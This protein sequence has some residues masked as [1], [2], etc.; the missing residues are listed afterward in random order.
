M[1]ARLRLL[2]HGATAATRSGS[3]ASDEPIE[4]R[5]RVRIS[6]LASQMPRFDLILTSPARRAL[7][8]AAALGLTA[9]VEPALRDA[10]FGRWRGRSLAQVFEEE[11]EAASLWSSEPQ[12][13][14][15]EGESISAVIER[16]GGWMDG[17]R[18]AGR[19]LAVTHAAVI[20][21]AAVHVLKAP[22]ASFWAIDVAPLAHV[23][24]THDG[25][26]WRLRAA[27]H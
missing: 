19:T 17:L 27:K 7:E 23:D 3:F 9:E 14:P 11:P 1:T 24:F 12:I 16:V 22:A 8:T 26:R 6:L 5:E 18:P 25:R 13:A 10:D 21:A 20:R 4:D 2:C 15:H